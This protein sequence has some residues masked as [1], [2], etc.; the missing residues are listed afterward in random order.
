MITLL[1]VG[2]VFNIGPRLALEVRGRHPDIL[3]LELDE[4][5]FRALKASGEARRN[6]PLYTLV[7]YFQ[8]RIARQFGAQ[9]GE[10]MLAAFDAAQELG[11]PV[12]F[13]DRESAVTWRRMRASMSR[14]EALKL[15]VS[16]LSSL[17]LGRP[18]VEQE[19][20][21]YREDFEGFMGEFERDLPSVKRV[22][23]DERNAYMAER[24][25]E[26][27]RAYQR[28]LAVVGDGH[29]RGLEAQLSGEDVEV[30][31]LWELRAELSEAARSEG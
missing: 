10:E 28:V 18:R 9:V 17:F 12:A 22:L 8:H 2:H 11:I 29:I 3:C 20:S 5:R 23:V 15:L 13:I 26:V 24:L 19:L 7:A 16:L 21:R 14:L 31:R 27:Q 30:V 25:R 4:P 1:G 6:P